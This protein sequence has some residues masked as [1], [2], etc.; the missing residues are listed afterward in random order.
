[1]ISGNK[2]KALKEIED[3][4]FDAL[5]S[6]FSSTSKI[7][8]NMKSW[9]RGVILFKKTALQVSQTVLKDMQE[10]SAAT[11]IRGKLTENDLN[12]G[13]VIVKDFYKCVNGGNDKYAE[14]KSKAFSLVFKEKVKEKVTKW[15]KESQELLMPKKEPK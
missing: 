10:I 8:F 11:Y 14:R 13:I 4:A 7:D 5:Q 2:T 6:S 3:I 9:E 12:Q 15:R 1:M